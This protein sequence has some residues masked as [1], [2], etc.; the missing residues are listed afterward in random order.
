MDIYRRAYLGTG[1][2]GK[3]NTT[4]VAKTAPMNFEFG[5]Y[6]N[7]HNVIFGLQSYNIAE[8]HRGAYDS[9]GGIM[10]QREIEE[11]DF[12]KQI[13]PLYSKQDFAKKKRKFGFLII[14][15]AAIIAFAVIIITAYKNKRS[16]LVQ[17]IF[18]DVLVAIL[19]SLITQKMQDDIEAYHSL[20]S[21][22][23]HITANTSAM[24][25]SELKRIEDFVDMKNAD[26]KKEQ[27]LAHYNT[28]VSRKDQ[29]H[30]IFKMIDLN[31]QHKLQSYYLQ[32]L[33][34]WIDTYR[35]NYFLISFDD[36]DMSKSFPWDDAI[37]LR[38]EI[39]A[40]DDECYID[41]QHNRHSSKM[42]GVNYDKE[43]SHYLY[44]RSKNKYLTQDLITDWEQRMESLLKEVKGYNFR[45]NKTLYAIY[46]LLPHK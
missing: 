42:E 15:L 2:F 37:G 32:R 10:G 22:Y 43:Q 35:K 8:K 23:V 41:N 7:I 18:N 11:N 25:E 39:A 27:S 34:E 40:Y 38:S 33:D 20:A 13:T 1:A 30:Y 28:A 46:E 14:I 16:E 29:L 44:D 3:T 17:L 4:E 19:V 26:E 24:D 45:R 9:I 21:I 5:N 6:N 31:A 36:P 12:R